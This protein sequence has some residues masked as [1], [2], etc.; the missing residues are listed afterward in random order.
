MSGL[1]LLEELVPNDERPADWDDVLRRAGR[2]RPRRRLAVAVVAVGA[3]LLVAPALAVLL[4]HD[5]GPQLPD[6]ADR[7]RVSVIVMPGTGRVLAK[8]AP[9]RNHDGICFAAILGRSGCASS[10]SAFMSLNAGYT[11]DRRVVSGTAVR[12]GSGRRM[13]LA[14]TRFPKLGVSVF[15]ARRDALRLLWRVEL[16]DAAGHVL[17]TIRNRPKR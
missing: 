17:H 7:S 13:P 9:W 6:A 3:T 16:R 1:Q 4:R 11:F 14:L 15:Y 8:L 12:L 2:R 10:G 5:R